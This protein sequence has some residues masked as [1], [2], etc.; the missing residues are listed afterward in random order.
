MSR[1]SN[2]ADREYSKRR[3]FNEEMHDSKV[4]RM[5]DLDGH[6]SVPSRKSCIRWLVRGSADTDLRRYV[7]GV[8]DDIGTVWRSDV[9]RC[10]FVQG[11]ENLDEASAHSD[12]ERGDMGEGCAVGARCARDRREILSLF[13]RKRRLSDRRQTRRRRH[14][15]RQDSKATA[16]SVSP[17]PTGP[18]DRT[19]TSSADRS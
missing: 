15:R 10:V 14:K 16:A 3:I 8:P 2:P 13:Q 7:L 1:R 17:W 5:C 12:D 4:C 18:K 11:H 9:V 19:A 6:V